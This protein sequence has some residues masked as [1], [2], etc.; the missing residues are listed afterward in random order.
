MALPSD[1]FDSYADKSAGSDLSYSANWKSYGFQLFEQYVSIKSTEPA[2]AFPK[3]AI[4]IGAANGLAMAEMEKHGLKTR[5]IESSRYIYDQASDDMKKKIAF[6]DATTL[7]ANIPDNAYDL[8]HDTVAQYVPK[9]DLK[10][11]LQELCRICVK[12]LVIVLHTID[13]NPEPHKCQVNH[14]HDVTWRRLLKDAGFVEKGPIDD[15]P[16]YFKKAS[17]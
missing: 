9:K 15:H 10:N 7:I 1:Y 13:L 11:Y 2:N 5:G 6:G 16:F 4:D 17:K 12:D 8:V 14:L 3:T